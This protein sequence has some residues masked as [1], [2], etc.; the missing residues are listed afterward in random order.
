MKK[1]HARRPP[2]GASRRMS[3][4]MLDVARR[5]RGRRRGAG[6]AGGGRSRRRR[7]AAAAPSRSGRAAGRRRAR[8]RGCARPASASTSVPRIVVGLQGDAVAVAALDLHPE[9]GEQ[10]RAAPRCRGSA[11]RCGARPARPSADTRPGAAAPRS[12][13]RR[14]RRCRESGTPPSMTNFSMRGG[15]G[16]GAGVGRAP[17]A[18]LGYQ[19]CRPSF[20]ARRPGPSSANGPSRRPC[21]STS[22]PSRRPCAPTRASSARTRSCGA[23]PAS[24]TTS[25]TSAI[26]TSRPGIRGSPWRSSR[27]RGY[28]PELVRAVASH[29]TFLGV[30]RDSP[31][32]EDAVRGRRALRLHHGLRVRAPDRASTG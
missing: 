1:S 27:Q 20:R 10:R 23:S 14:A 25:T 22:W 21:A 32:G 24:S 5:A 12:C 11:A 16:R 31:D 7:A 8:R 6:P 28:P 3:P 15:S 17:E 26:R 4:S 13:S 9:V 18:G 30:S 19:P 2:S 29:A